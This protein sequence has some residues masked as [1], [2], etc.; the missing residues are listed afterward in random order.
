MAPHL[1]KD[2]KERI[3][4]A[5]EAGKKPNLVADMF[6][7]TL[8]TVQMLLV[9]S[10]TR[11]EGVSRKEG[12]GGHNKKRTEE[13]KR[14]MVEKIAQNPK[15]SA[16]KLA[17]DTGVSHSTVLETLKEL[18]FKSY[19]QPVAQLVTTPQRGTR[20]ERC[21]KLL[22]LVKRG[23]TGVILFTDEKIFVQDIHVNRRNS[24]VIARSPDERDDHMAFRSKHPA[25]VMV[26]G[27]V[28]SDGNKMP[29]VMFPP[30][31]RL[32]TEGYLTVLQQV[33][34]CILSTYPEANVPGEEGVI[35]PEFRFTFMQDGAPAH[36]SIGA[37]AWLKN[38]FGEARFWAKNQ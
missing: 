8:R 28:A 10:R 22:N 24:R 23:K 21:L 32:N 26:F 37:Q 17:R 2:T 3:V 27:L 34:D 25:S 36:T 12:S 29:L 1:S 7:V 13:F 38:N 11:P 4:A 5:V 6:G 19:A 18:G 14:D 35:N 31:F 20:V 16:R 15:V 33:K 9:K 30:R